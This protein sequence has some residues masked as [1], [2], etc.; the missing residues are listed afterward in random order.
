MRTVR[1][2]R[3]GKEPFGGEGGGGGFPHGAAHGASHGSPATHGGPS[4]HASPAPHGS[5]EPHGGPGSHGLRPAPHVSVP[6]L[7]AIACGVAHAAGAQTAGA[8][9]PGPGHHLPAS[10]LGW[11]P[12][13]RLALTGEFPAAAVSEA[14]AAARAADPARVRV[15]SGTAHRNAV[16]WLPAWQRAVVVR[17][18]APSVAVRRERGFYSEHNVLEAIH[19]TYGDGHPGAPR[20]PRVL[21]LGRDALGSFALHTYEGPLPAP[22]RV[23]A[24]R[25]T[26]RHPVNGLR[27]R[28][29]DALV[30]QLAALSRVDCSH[31]EPA[32]GRPEFFAWLRAELVRI[33]ASLPAP[34]LDRAHASGLPGPAALEALLAPLTVTPR[35]PGLLHGDLNPWNLVRLPGDDLA[36]IDW[37]LALTG[38]PLHELIRHLHL[39]PARP[40][41]RAR[42]VTRWSR[43][44]SPDRTAGW[45]DDA[46]L[47]THIERLRSAYL[48]L[49]RIVMGSAL[50]APNVARAVR[51]YGRTLTAAHASLTALSHRARGVEGRG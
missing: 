34:V 13:E 16:V 9:A 42:M 36:L 46:P 2:G 51:R 12:D 32:A 25:L 8:R 24:E 38:D 4:S 5:H 19:A 33:V 31:L 45:E 40:S 3:Q 44:L 27:V 10:P 11:T 20:V 29:A 43:A 7:H 37:E 50:D 1:S 22:G 47:Y 21:A 48:D 14:L 23:T 35:T 17:R 6:R 49:D 41:L 30:D 15:L 26:P 18:F 28:E 39:A